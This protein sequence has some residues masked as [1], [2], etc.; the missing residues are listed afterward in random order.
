MEMGTERPADRDARRSLESKAIGDCSP[1]DGRCPGSKHSQLPVNS[2]TL[3]TLVTAAVNCLTPAIGG[4]LS[5]QSDPRAIHFRRNRHS[6]AIVCGVARHGATLDYSASGGEGIT[7][8]G[9]TPR[10]TLYPALV[11]CLACIAAFTRDEQRA[12]VGAITE[13]EGC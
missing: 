3:I 5:I 11:T 7:R 4:A 12:S 6:H 9:H 10:T 8:I 1:I 13:P 2:L